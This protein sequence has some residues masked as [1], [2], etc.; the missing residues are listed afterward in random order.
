MQKL[1]KKK[2]GIYKI[3]GILMLCLTLLITMCLS[4]LAEEPD[5]GDDCGT[6]EPI[7]PNGMIIQGILDT[8]D[9]DWF[10]FTASADGLYEIMIYSQSGNKSFA[11][12][13]PDDCVTLITFGYFNTG[14]QTYNVFIETGGTYYLNVYYGS[15]LYQLSVNE[16]ATYTTDTYPDICANANDLIVDGP[17]LYDGITDGGIDEDW[18]TV[19]T[20]VLHK[21]HIN[22]YSPLNT[23]VQ[24]SLY[25]DNCTNSLYSSFGAMDFVSP[26]GNDYKLR[27]NSSSFNKEGYYEI[28]VEDSGSVKIPPPFSPLLFM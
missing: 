28:S 16:I 18:F 11:M 25:E 6:A 12:Y 2:T 20:E 26:D 17:T 23:D 19:Q 7:D 14:S 9:W 10:R 15:G 1:I 22:F 5:Y 27:V 8:G 13:G 4:S 21:Y 3:K 24:C